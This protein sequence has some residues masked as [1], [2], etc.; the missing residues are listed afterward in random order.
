MMWTGVQCTC[1]PALRHPAHPAQAVPA[2]LH[3]L[4]Q[5]GWIKWLLSF[6]NKMYIGLKHATNYCPSKKSLPIL[7]SKLLHKLGQ[8]FKDIQYLE[9]ESTLTADRNFIAVISKSDKWKKSQIIT[10]W[11]PIKPRYGL[12][13]Y[14]NVS[15][16]IFNMDALTKYVKIFSLLTILH[17]KVE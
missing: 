4:H 7:Y 3:H 5:P 16:Y 8:D 12:H 14:K 15:I 11:L 6:A 17:M 1:C 13:M 2:R 9:S 10:F